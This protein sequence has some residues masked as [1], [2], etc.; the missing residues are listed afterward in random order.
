MTP[1]ERRSAECD[2][3]V[4]VVA[5]T[6]SVTQAWIAASI[7]LAASAAYVWLLWPTCLRQNFGDDAY[8]HATFAKNLA[9]GRGFIF[10]FPPQV[11]GSTSPL[12]VL[13]AA[14]LAWLL[15]AW[16][17]PDA[18]LAITISAWIGAHL[19]LW[20]NLRHEGLPA[21]ASALAAGLCLLCV[22][23]WESELGMEFALFEF[24]LLAVAWTYAR[25]RLM[26]AGILAG[27]LPLVR[28]E[29]GLIGPVLVAHAVWS[30]RRVPWSLVAGGTVVA[31]AWTAYAWPTFGTLVPTTFDAKRMHAELSGQ[32][33]AASTVWRNLRFI[34]LDS[35]GLGSW[36]SINVLVLLAAIGTAASLQ[37]RRWLALFLL[38][39]AAVY[40]LGI[41]WANP[42]VFQRYSLHLLFVAQALAAMGLAAITAA[43]VRS[44]WPA[45]TA[46]TVIVGASCAWMLIAN[47]RAFST[48][49][50]GSG[51]KLAPESRA[52][53]RWFNTH[54]EPQRSIALDGI[55]YPG[56]FTP[57]RIIDLSG[58]LDPGVVELV[59]EGGIESSLQQMAP[60]FV[61]LFEGRWFNRRLWPA[62][63]EGYEL[64]FE[65]PQRSGGQAAWIFARKDL[66]QSHR[67]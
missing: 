52:L 62:V 3:S 64:A 15:P 18:L 28:P 6:R 4:E 41:E 9:A 39:W 36:R 56:Y 57:N 53:C 65:L 43:A 13:L 14:L 45:R 60:D 26:V 48:L 24:L 29:G 31:F 20:L 55:G 1:C 10:N 32:E 42:L 30:T 37:A 40:T 5:P 17:A 49:R 16:S 2:A 47:E 27:L 22:A 34:V 19:M 7:L 33:S 66:L 23:G 63:Q 8:I 21:V 50:E 67:R 44:R 35:Y 25:S 54:A 51:T 38:A 11:L 46:W 59:R 61:V 12:F 58:M